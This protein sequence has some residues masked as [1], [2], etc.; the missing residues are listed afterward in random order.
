[1]VV[2]PVVVAGASVVLVSSVVEV[3]SV[4][5][6]VSVEVDVVL[7]QTVSDDAASVH[8]C[9]GTVPGPHIRRSSMAML[10]LSLAFAA[11]NIWSCNTI[12]PGNVSLF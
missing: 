5:E 7:I 6:V 12:D 10:S 1:M 11:P 3:R 4:V 2:A 8:I 9:L